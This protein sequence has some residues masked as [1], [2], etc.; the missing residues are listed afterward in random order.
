MRSTDE[1]GYREFAAVQLQALQ[2]PAYL[3]CGDWH[4]AQDLVQTALVKMYGAWSRLERDVDRHAYA[5]RVLVNAYISQ[6]RRHWWRREISSAELTESAAR[7][8]A[9]FGEREVQRELLMALPARQRAVIVLRFWEDFSV[10]QTAQAL[11]IATGTV[12]SQSA[13][14][15]KTL[16]IAVSHE[17]STP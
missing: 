14:A 13:E 7:E 15:L 1:D 2:R 10:E 8:D 12:K 9:D 5:R 16:R 4:L 17:E 3:L 11:G 6:Q